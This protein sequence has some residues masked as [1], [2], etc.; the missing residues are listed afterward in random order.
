MIT[1]VPI[2]F[3]IEINIFTFGFI[4][5]HVILVKLSDIIFVKC[6]AQKWYHATPLVLD[7]IRW[8]K[9]VENIH[10]SLKSW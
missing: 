7:G 6:S 8:F 9:R 5:F 3:I 10:L 1:N 2:S 4:W